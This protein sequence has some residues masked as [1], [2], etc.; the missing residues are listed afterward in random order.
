L[1][2][3]NRR[4]KG[5][6]KD[7][8]IRQTTCMLLVFLAVCVGIQTEAKE[9]FVDDFSKGLGKWE[10]IGDGKI[11]IADDKTAPNFGPK[12]LKLDNSAGTN[13]IAYLNGFELTDGVIAY[14]L[15]DLNE[16]NN[17]DLDADGPGFARLM[18]KDDIPVAS[19]F[20]TGYTIE[21]DL[22][23]GFHILWG[24]NGNGDNIVVT[25]SPKATSDWT[26]IKFSLIGN[27]LK[28]KTW[29]ADKEE[30][31]S[32]QLEGKDDRYSKGA[33]AMRVWSGAMHVAYIRITDK[34]EPIPSA[35]Q[36]GTDK[37]AV[38]WGLL[39]R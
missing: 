11:E 24:D 1:L 17:A 10:H 26:W 8:M 25:G 22:D 15:K 29:L 36:P 39:K 4:K 5:L 38:T 21:L 28:G 19:A 33:V 35:V 12:V 16:A 6:E 13:C 37:L 31:G 18:Q 32:W 34:D 7:K 9:L 20:P 14:L 2:A 23:G 30:P 3:F 27:E